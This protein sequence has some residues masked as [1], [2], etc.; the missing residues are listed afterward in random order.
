MIIREGLWKFGGKPFWRAETPLWIRCRPTSHVSVWE[1]SCETYRVVQRIEARVKEWERA[2]TGEVVF[3][4][5][6]PGMLQW[7]WKKLR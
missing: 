1:D 7:K 2:T 3:G 4:G 6:Q 5:C